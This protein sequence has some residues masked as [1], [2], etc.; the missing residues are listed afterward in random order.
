VVI[1]IYLKDVN[2]PPD[3]LIKQQQTESSNQSSN[4][5]SNNA[6]V[7]TVVTKKKR[8]SRTPSRKSGYRTIQ[9]YY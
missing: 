4:Q 8:A 5:D 6:S 9:S 2:V 7:E 1:A 3:A